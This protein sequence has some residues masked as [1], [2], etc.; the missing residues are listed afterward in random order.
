M[1]DTEKK[2]AEAG[3]LIAAAVFTPWHWERSNTLAMQV[4]WEFGAIIG[5]AL[6]SKLASADNNEHAA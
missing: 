2:C 5:R 1:T 4:G 3:A 6:D